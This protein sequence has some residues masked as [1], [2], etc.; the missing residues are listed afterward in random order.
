VVDTKIF[1][2]QELNTFRTK[3]IISEREY[4]P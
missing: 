2:N 3:V 1:A 4:F